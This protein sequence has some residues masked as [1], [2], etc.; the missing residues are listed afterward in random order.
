MSSNDTSRARSLMAARL[1]ARTGIDSTWQSAFAAVP[2]EA[3]LPERVWYNRN[4]RAV[5]VKRSDDP[6]TWWSLVHD[7]ERSII[8]QLDDGRDGGPGNYSSSSTMPLVMA[9]MLA[10]LPDSGR[11]LE[12]G[13]GSGYNAAILAHRY[14]AENVVSVEVD[15]TIA[16][17]ATEA[18]EHAG[19]PVRVV[20]ADAV[21]GYGVPEGP[22]DAIIATCGFRSLPEYWLDLCPSGRIVVPWSTRWA[23]V[24]CLRLDT[25]NGSATGRFVRGFVFMDARA[26]R[27][28]AD[29]PSDTS[30]G[31]ERLS[32]LAPTHV[33]WEA[34]YAAFSVG[35]LAPGI[36]YHR[37]AGDA[38][39]TCTVWDSDGSWAV[40]DE[41]PTEDG[42]RVRESGPR[43]LW[44][45]IEHVHKRWLEWDEPS[46]DRFGVS[47][48]NA[49]AFV[50]LD[51][52]ERPVTTLPMTPR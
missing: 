26:H 43:K 12:I 24:P 23:D 14:G 2:R 6:D 51:S 11:V 44:Q 31:D 21:T 15:P 49:G 36:D 37:A 48:T 5:E 47:V 32:Q 3:F 30:R 41:A 13:T 29:R 42:W 1:G 17:Q 34:A 22:F 8:I 20:C 28:P 16:G 40:I 39:R 38:G 7:E 33:S 10:M 35:L 18:T 46:P 27:S 19:Y 9:R 25:H 4:H 52:A 50:W 45:I